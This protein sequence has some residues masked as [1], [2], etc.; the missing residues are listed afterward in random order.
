MEMFEKLWGNARKMKA[1]REPNIMFII[2]K[3]FGK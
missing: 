3:L 2:V 1:K